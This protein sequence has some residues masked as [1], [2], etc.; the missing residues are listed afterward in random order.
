[1]DENSLVL[2]EA[3]ALGIKDRH[4]SREQK[5]NSKCP[6]KHTAIKSGH[7]LKVIFGFISFILEYLSFFVHPRIGPYTKKPAVADFLVNIIQKEQS[8]ISNAILVRELSARTF[9]D[10]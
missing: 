6:K 3:I 7:S 5:K 8:L 4:W 2:I 1:V 10:S 9:A